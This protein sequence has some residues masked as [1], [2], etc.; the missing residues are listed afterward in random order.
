MYDFFLN[1]GNARI[2]KSKGDEETL[3]GRL[4]NDGIKE[5]RKIK[6]ANGLAKYI[7]HHVY[8]SYC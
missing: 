1:I 6:Y 2:E 4:N 8:C 7:V 3:L 5:S